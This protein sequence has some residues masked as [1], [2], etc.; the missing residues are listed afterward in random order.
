MTATGPSEPLAESLLAENGVDVELLSTALDGPVER[1]ETSMVGTGQVGENVRCRL[2]WAEP[3][4]GSGTRPA[5]VIVKL[6]SSNEKSREAAAVTRTY[7]REVGF[8]RDLAAE[9]AIR[10]PKPYHATEERDA[11]RFVLIM[12]DMAPARVGNQLTGCSVEEA[13]AALASA[14]DLHG[15]T[16]DRADLES[17]DW[18]DPI[19]EERMAERAALFTALYEGFESMYHDVLTEEEHTFGRALNDRF[20]RYVGAAGAPRCLIHGDFRLDN[21]LLGDGES[22][23]P[24]TTVDWQT[25]GRGRPM[26]DVAY[27]L[28]GSLDAETLRDREE[29]LLNGYF[30]RLGSHGVAADT[31]ALTAE[32]RLAAP[33]GFIMAVVASQIVGRTDRGDEM[34]MVMARGSARLA[35]DVGTLDLLD[36]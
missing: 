35:A 16:W 7:I 2:T 30:D 4:D 28:S 26:S 9:V 17:F 1:L 36:G 5:S 8:Y 21:L 19:T 32:Y 25:A 24:V 23:P 27:F 22:A 3:D 31:E 6:A 18:I 13:V 29:E 33:A 14:A 20:E 11:N 15:S 34:F 12:E 10:V